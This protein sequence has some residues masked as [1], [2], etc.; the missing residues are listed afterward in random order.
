[1]AGQRLNLQRVDNICGKRRFH[2]LVDARAF[3]RILAGKNQV[4][5]LRQAGVAARPLLVQGLRGVPC[6]GTS[7][8]QLE[9]LG[10]LR[11]SPGLESTVRPGP[12]AHAL[13]G[14][15]APLGASASLGA[16][17]T[18]DGAGGR[19]VPLRPSARPTAPTRIARTMVPDLESSSSDRRRPGWWR[20]D[21]E[22]TQHILRTPTS[23]WGKCTPRRPTRSTPARGLLQWREAG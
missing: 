17:Q 18:A 12:G 1:M 16:C 11:R 14:A 6:G 2:D 20:R 13:L 4:T 22:W 10:D 7:G 5:G 19:V 21:R 8:D 9:Q 3:T 23:P 15:C